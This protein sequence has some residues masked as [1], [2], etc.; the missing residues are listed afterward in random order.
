MKILHL[1]HRAPPF[2][3]G[4]ERY[5]FEHAAAGARWGHESVIATTDAWDMS[6]MTGRH[7]RRVERRDEAIRGVRILRFPVFHPPG[8]D[9]LRAALRRLAPGG[10]DRFFYPNPFVPALDSWIRRDHGFS[11]VHSNAMPF[12]LRAGWEHARR[13]GTV[14]VSV[15]HAN[16]GEKFRRAD[17]LRYFEGTQETV[18]A[19]SSLVVAQSGFERDLF[20]GMGVDDERILVLGSGVDP[21]EFQHASGDRARAALGI[22]GPVVLSMTAHCLDRGS[23]DLLDACE[24]LW[25]KGERFTLVLAGPVLADFEDALERGRA[26]PR[27]G[28]V[29]IRGFV[30]AEERAELLAAADV[31]AL[32][33]RLDCF[34]IV[35]LEA[36]LMG[37]PVLGCWSGA[38]AE[39]IVDGTNGFL[40][41]FGDS[42]TIAD[43]L[44]RLLRD[45]AAGKAMG[46]AGRSH[47]L[48]ERTWEKVTDRFYRRVAECL[49]ER[50][51]EQRAQRR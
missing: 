27:P 42:V 31:V 35:I 32:P 7:G 13:F 30:R 9:I 12:V 26:R 33:S 16:V 45:P 37:K 8:Q 22:E 21:S 41:G 2:S 48:A 18:L 47:V 5:V 15:P 1:V 14:L 6:W 29:I 10:P 38:M 43:R 20:L 51:P 3:G 11:M 17:A 34:G 19:G 49:P 44:S 39:M 50:L 23:L 28:R 25:S 36:W 40:T 24:A 4:A 46:A